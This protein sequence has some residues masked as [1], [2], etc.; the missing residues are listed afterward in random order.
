MKLLLDQNI[1]YRVANRVAHIF[2]EVKQVRQLGLENASDT[3]IWSYAKDHN[4][5]IVTFDSDFYDLS[6]VRGAPPKI[7]WI[8]T[9]NLTSRQIEVILEEHYQ[10][11]AAFFKDELLD[12]LKIVR[13]TP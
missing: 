4:F 2:P 10:S 6:L 11:I 3:E 13:D 12:C 8:K 9:G 5:I 1:S 7:I